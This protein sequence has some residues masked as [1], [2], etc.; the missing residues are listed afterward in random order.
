MELLVSSIGQA[1]HNVKKMNIEHSL[2]CEMKHITIVFLKLSLGS[3]FYAGCI[4]A[5]SKH[6]DFVSSKGIGLGTFR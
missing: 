1:F 6:L 5:T 3:L 4:Q 2:L